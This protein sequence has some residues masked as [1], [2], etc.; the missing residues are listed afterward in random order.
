[1]HTETLDLCFRGR[2]GLL[3][4]THRTSEPITDDDT[5]F[6]ASNSKVQAS[7]GVIQA[8]STGTRSEICFLLQ[9]PD[10][11][12]SFP[13][14]LTTSHALLAFPIIEPHSLDSLTQN[15]CHGL[16]VSHLDHKSSLDTRPSLD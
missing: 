3:S 6:E 12:P 7:K 15:K 14:P 11:I 9:E 4:R 13:A 2:A 5:E 16:K 10:A 8:I 1:M